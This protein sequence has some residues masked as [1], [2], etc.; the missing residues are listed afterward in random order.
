MAA[1]D[2]STED[3]EQA[4]NGLIQTLSIAVPLTL[5]VAGAGGAFLAGR[6]LRPVDQI[7]NTARNIQ[8]ADLTQRIAVNTRDELGRLASTLNQMI[9]RLENAFNRQTASTSLKCTAAA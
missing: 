4:L 1:N 3:I 9:E 8:E 7:A 6:A 2:R 5:L